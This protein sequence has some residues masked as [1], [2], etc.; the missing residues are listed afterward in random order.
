MVESGT[1][2]RLEGEEF[3]TL[4]PAA[5]LTALPEGLAEAQDII[6]LIF[7]VG[8]VIALLR[9]SGAID[10]FLHGAVKRLG[11]APWILIAGTLAVFG[12]GSFTIGMGE[13]YLPL[14]PILVTMALA[15]K[16]DSIVAMG[17]IWVPYGIGWA[18]AGT[19]PFGVVIAQ[20]IAGVP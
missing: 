15:M 1:Y 20:G 4:Q 17:M 16:L 8:G 19:N 7:L 2:H 13:E 12:L 14:I 6:F 9:E 10:A 18:T 3:V 5:F 11:R